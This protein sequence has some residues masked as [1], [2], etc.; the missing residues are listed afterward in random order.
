[1]LFQRGHDYA[2]NRAGQHGA[3]NDDGVARGL[4]LQGRADLLANAFYM[5]EI[6]TAVRVARRADANQR[7][8]RVLNCF[9]CICR[10][11]QASGWNHFFDQLGQT[12]FD[13]G[14]FAAVDNFHLWLG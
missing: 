9:Q 11:A 14:T 3:A 6:Q 2:F 8:F 4:G 12:G 13:D 5:I 1:M 7:D 10:G